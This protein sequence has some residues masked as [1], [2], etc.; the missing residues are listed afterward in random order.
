MELR[1]GWSAQAVLL[2]AALRRPLPRGERAARAGLCAA[3]ESGDWAC[4]RHLREC[5]CVTAVLLAGGATSLNGR[6]A[7]R[8]ARLC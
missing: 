1:A 5:W 8:F 6:R 3:I 2:A 7:N 4:M